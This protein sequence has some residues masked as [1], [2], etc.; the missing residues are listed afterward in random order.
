MSLDIID[1]RKIAPEEI[2]P[3]SNSHRSWSPWLAVHLIIQREG[4]RLGLRSLQTVLQYLTLL[5]K[6]NV[7]FLQSD[8]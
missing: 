7:I 2:P 4:H 5:F 1:L 6:F 3:F 8:T